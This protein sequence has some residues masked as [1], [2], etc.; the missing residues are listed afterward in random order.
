MLDGG[1]CS[2]CQGT[3]KKEY[4]KEANDPH[5]CVSAYSGSVNLSLFRFIFRQPQKN[6][7]S[8]FGGP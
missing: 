5:L 7:M 4:I 6:R 1:A 3:W 2:M 8:F